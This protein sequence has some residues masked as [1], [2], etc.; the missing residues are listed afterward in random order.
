M[1]VLHDYISGA[2]GTN[3][4]IDQRLNNIKIISLEDTNISSYNETPT[5]ETL[6]QLNARYAEA[7][8]PFTVI[9]GFF[10]IIGIIGNL[11]VFIVYGFGKQFKDKKFRYYV[12]T[13][14]FIDFITCLTLIPAEMMKHV[15][16]F[17]FTE[18]E[19]CKTKCFFNVFAASSASYCLTLIA[20]DR[21]IMTCHPIFFAK[22]QK[23]SFSF[24]ARLC[25]LMQFLALLTSLPAAFLCGITQSTMTGINGSEINVYLCE[26]EPYYESNPLRYIYRIL[27]C[28]TQTSISIIMIILYARIGHAV[29]T[30]MKIR[31]CKHGTIKMAELKLYGG[32]QSNSVTHGCHA[33]SQSIPSKIKLLFVVTVVFIVTYLCY[34]SLSWVDQTKL[35]PTQFFFF[36]VAFRSY[37]IHSIINPFLYT[38]MDRYF[39]NRCLKLF[40]HCLR[41]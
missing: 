21:Y 28:A 24:A 2:N 29:R 13:L 9:L 38:K 14:A 8:L 26:T 4:K 25:I 12:L 39:R 19:L 30:V 34:M 23:Y 15:S 6:N 18:R 32:E 40:R 37:F 3:M 22:L 35:S 5:A 27:L 11:L 33:C 36:S 31:E 1:S 10:G 20:A 17:K 41:C 7:L 16:Y